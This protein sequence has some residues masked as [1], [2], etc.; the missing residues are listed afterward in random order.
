MPTKVVRRDAES[1]EAVHLDGSSTL[2]NSAGAD[3]WYSANLDD[4]G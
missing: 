4:T 3:E 2:G 1:A